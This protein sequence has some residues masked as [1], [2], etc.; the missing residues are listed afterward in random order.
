VIS[1]TRHFAVADCPAR[2]RGSEASVTCTALPSRLRDHYQSRILSGLRTYALP[3]RCPLTEPSLFVPKRRS[4]EKALARSRSRM[5]RPQ[6]S[7]GPPG[8][9]TDVRAS[10][11]LRSGTPTGRVDLIHEHP[12][13]PVPEVRPKT[14]SRIGRT[15]L[16]FGT[17]AGWISGAP[18]FDLSPSTDITHG[19]CATLHSITRTR[20]RSWIRP[21]SCA[22]RL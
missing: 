1:V 12:G 2:R 16:T 22:G 19:F 8:R 15:V 10:H 13:R 7:P 17:V 21:P 3:D 18:G 6:S 9:H 11:I 20:R 14:A 5:P 4:L